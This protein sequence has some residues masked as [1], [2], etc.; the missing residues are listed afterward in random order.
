[1]STAEARRYAPTPKAA[2]PTPNRTKAAPTAIMPAAIGAKDPAIA[3]KTVMTPATTDIAIAADLMF[4]IGNSPTTLIAAARTKIAADT[5][6]MAAAPTKAPFAMLAAAAA[7][8]MTTD[9]DPPA[10]TMDF[11]S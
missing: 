4:S 9:N 10:A 1:M 3:P 7:A 11:Q 6:T 8:S 2:T 5:T